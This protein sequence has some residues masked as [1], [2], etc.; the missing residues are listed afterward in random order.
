MIDLLRIVDLRGFIVCYLIG[1][2]NLT[3]LKSGLK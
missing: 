2:F 3:P 1:C